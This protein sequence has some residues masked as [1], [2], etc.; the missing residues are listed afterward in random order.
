[1]KN[2]MIQSRNV[3]GCVF[4]AYPET[5]L[6]SPA[7]SPTHYNAS[8]KMDTRPDIEITQHMVQDK[9]LTPGITQN[10]K[11]HEGH[12]GHSAAAVHFSLHDRW[13]CLAAPFETNIYMKWYVHK[14]LVMQTVF[15]L[16]YGWDHKYKHHFFI[17]K[18]RLKPQLNRITQKDGCIQ[19]HMHNAVHPTQ[20]GFLYLALRMLEYIKHGCV[21][22][23]WLPLINRG[24]AWIRPGPGPTWICK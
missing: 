8:T 19:I 14:C 3:S 5:L 21:L 6:F 18:P 13:G 1:M 24:Q 20:G 7:V 9:S 15:K 22:G 4:P 11:K 16:K 2:W 12:Q 23:H 10:F 17:W